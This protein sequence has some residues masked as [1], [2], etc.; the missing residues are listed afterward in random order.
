VKAVGITGYKKSGKTTLI[1]NLAQEL[2]KRDYK[3]ATIKHTPEGID[4]LDRDTAKHK[5]YAQQ[6]A[7]VSSGESAIF[8]NSRKSLEDIA[9]YMEADFL[10]IEGFKKEKTFP[11][12]ICLK[13]AHEAERLLDGLE[14]CAATISPVKIK[15][16]LPVFSIL[17]DIEKIADL[18][19][20]KAFKLPNL[21]CG[22]CGHKTC[23]GLAREIVQGEKSI[24]DCV[25]LKSTTQVT[26]NGQTLALN[27]FAAKIIRN[28][29]KGALS[30]LK[31]FRRGK[32]E[33]EINE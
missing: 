14:I 29:I 11:K 12:I 2:S 4:L 31:G 1:V 7:A 5:K 15:L 10:L 20:K 30:T 13:D 24:G 19:E 22:S 23:Y 32:I 26:L 8:F 18:V 3:V 6:V 17:N 21:N 25:S 27:P 16:G 9:R 33:I 28:T